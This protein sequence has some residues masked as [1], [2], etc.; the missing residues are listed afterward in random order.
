MG[1]LLAIAFLISLPTAAQTFNARLTGTVTDPSGAAVPSA[2]V[3]AVQVQTSVRRAASTDASGV[4][5][6]PLLLPGLYEVLIEAPGFEKQVRRDVRLEVN[7][8]ATADF[9]LTVGQVAVSVDVTAEIPLLQSETSGVGATIENKL[10]E[11]YP[12]PQ[13]DAMGLLR[14]LPGVIASSDIGD[15]RGNRNVFNSNFS[16]G[17]GRTSTNEVLL[18]GA[19]NTIGDF[20]GVVIVP[21]LD[22]VQELR[23]ETS[24]YSAE[25]GRSGGG[26]VNMVTKSGTNEFHGSAYYYHQ[27][28]AFN[29]NTFANNRRPL[30]DGRAQPK[31][32][33]RRHQFGGTFGGPLVLPTLYNGKN[34]TFYFFSYEGRR[35]KNP[36]QGLFSSPTA[37]EREGDFSQ[38]FIIPGPNAAPQLVQIFNPFTSRLLPNGQGVRDPFPGNA[39]PRSLLSPVAAR[40]LQDYPTGNQPGDPVTNRNNYFFRDAQRYSRDLY[41]GRLDH[42]LSEA[43][44]LFGRMNYQE[45]LERNPGNIVKFASTNSTSDWFGNLGLD[46]TYQLSPRL[47]NVFRWSYTR[48]RANLFPNTTLGVDPTSLGLPAYMRDNAAI[49]YYPNF[50]FGFT[51]MGGTAYNFQPRD[52]Q[53]WQ[54]QMVWVKGRHNLRFGGEY[55]LLRFYPFQITNPTG[56][57]D[58]S[59]IMTQQNH[60]AAV[61][62]AEG[63]AFAS[64]LLGVSTGFQFEYRQPLTAFQH[65]AAGFVQD[66]WKITSRLTLNLGLRYDLETGTAEAHDRLSCFDPDARNPLVNGPRGAILFTGQGN[67]RSIRAANRKRFG[68]RA[69]FAF[70][71]DNRTSIRGGYG[72]FYLPV[73]VEPGLTTTDT[74]YIVTADSVNPDYS[75]RTTLSDPFGGRITPPNE[76]RRANDGSYLLGLNASIVLRLLPP[77]YMQQ[78]NFAVSRQIGRSMVADA[79]YFGS[80]GVHLPVPNVE[81]NQIHADNLQRGRQYLTELVP[82]PFLGQFTT[83][84]LSRPTVPRMQLLKPYPQFA[85]RST[86]D[87]FGG[88]LFWSRPPLGDSV[89]HAATFRL[90]RRFSGGL[91]VNAHYTVSKLIDIGGVGNGLAFRDVSGIR[92]I[93]NVRLER[94]LSAWDVPQRLVVN[95]AVELPFGKGKPLLNRTG[96]VDAV[97]GGWQVFSV[98]TWESGRPIAVGGPNLSRIAST[99]PSRVTVVPGVAAKLPMDQSRANAR[100]YDPRCNCTRPWFNTTA[101]AATPEFVM[102]NGPRFLPDVRQDSTR[103]W[104]F[105][106]TKK[107]R[108]HERWNFVLSANFFNFLNQ[109]YFG[110]PTGDV[111]SAVFGSTASI[112]SAARR[113]EMGAKVVF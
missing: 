1:R 99:G 111:Q 73:G 91:S 110:A 88:S 74:S 15:A 33:V 82:N 2:T 61:R 100:D 10:I 50:S 60:R 76:L 18:D 104:D 103:N 36:S 66:D 51:G 92:D 75:P 48:Y 83:G 107:L 9:S 43:H 34:R 55:R 12:L 59:A 19:P 86:A 39:V 70:R 21:A 28:D 29:A 89:Y 11:Q 79:T 71:L 24:S 67:P 52:T 93:H 80:R 84:L 63:S 14:S 8:T 16:V 20:N 5:N 27:N 54:E 30:A 6:I 72:V 35:E 42:Y 37:R 68:P 106:V 65:Y 62:P 53:S 94:S 25:F 58:F 22:S 97:L 45:N 95:Y 3:T 113:V 112:N 46:D 96:A 13:R 56:L 78:W 41:S 77:A 17:G 108:L 57:Y 32:L 90:E 87:A 85:N 109:T 81:L 23:V 31:P 44:R 47:N 102:P 69:G 26:T 98:H 49:L 4:Y 38:T 40:V 101:F 105:S 7:Q 64:F